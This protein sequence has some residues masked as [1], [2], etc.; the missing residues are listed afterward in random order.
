MSEDIKPEKKMRVQ[1][2]GM[3]CASCALKIE[4]SLNKLPGVKK[5]TVNFNLEN[6]YIEYD[7]KK[8]GFK[9]FNAAIEDI[10]YKSNL[11]RIELEISLLDSLE[12]AQMIQNFL[13]RQEGIYNA[14]VN[15]S[16]KVANIEYN[17]EEI[18]S[19]V[20]IQHI[21]RLGFEAIERVS[22]IDSEQLERE[23]EIKKQKFKFLFALIL[24][25]PI[26]TLSMWPTLNTLNE[27]RLLLFF[28]T[29]P[30]IVYSGNQFFIGSYRALRN[31][32][33]NMDVLV[34]LSVSVSFIYSTLVTFGVI[35]G[36]HVFYEAAVMILT[37]ILLGKYLEAIA[38]GR[39]S[40]AIKKL[41]GL[42]AKSATILR[43]GK[44][45]EIP[46]DEVQIGDT[47]ISKPGEKIPVDGVIIDGKTGIDESMITGESRLVKKRVGDSVI[48]A[49]I[50]KTGLIKFETKKIGKDTVLSQIIKLVQDAQS[51]KAPIQRLAD[52]VAGIFVPIV[53]L[54]AIVTFILWITIG[55]Q[56]LETALLAMTSVIV[57]AC[58]CA[59]GLAIPTAIM[60]GTGKGA[61]SGLLIKGG[62]SLEA[63]YKLT[64]V[65]FDKT[66]TLT[67]GKPEVTDIISDTLKD[68]DILRL[69]GSAEKGS[70]HPL[71]DAIISSANKR[72]ITLTSPKDFEEIPGNGIVAKIDTQLVYL[73]NQKLMDTHNIPVEKYNA[74]I[75]DLQ[76][77]GKTITYLA[78]NGQIEAL[79]GIADAIK[80]SSLS[81]IKALQ[82]KGLEVIMLTGDNTKTAHAIASQ[83]NIKNVISEILPQDKANQIKKLQMEGKKIVAMV[84]DGINDA[85]AL[86]QADVGIA[87]G[88]GTDVAIETGDIVLMRNDLRDVVAAINLSKKTV[89]KMKTNLFWAFIYNI[90]GIPLAAG[91]LFLLTGF[92][93][94]PGLAAAF[95]A[96][97]SVSVVTN[98]LLLK[99]YNPKMK[100]QIEED[101]RLA[102][103]IAIDPVCHMEVIPGKSLDSEYKGKTYYF[104]NP[105]CKIEFE[106]NPLKYITE[107]G[108]IP[109]EPLP[110]EL[111]ETPPKEVI[112]LTDKKPKLKC[113]SCNTTQEV[114]MHCGKPMHIEKVD[115]KP[116][117]VCWMGPGCG[118]Q[119]I[120]THHNAPMEYVE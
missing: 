120:P 41:L 49:T 92:F 38:K 44:E 99:S 39:T 104:C 64:T 52:R 70:D 71:A 112:E 108:E 55:G 65:V 4:N 78:V 85:P 9:N 105:N 47:V 36:M 114:P 40:E 83:L 19:K 76:V 51:Q 107:T 26:V 20:I 22:A 67:K 75:N 86:A 98:S 25:I 11:S 73:G 66:G 113:K 116:M 31:K 101:A 91:V 33:A 8:T 103:E 95:M 28:L 88:S 46:I 17:S 56:P 100:E 84:G 106:R 6:A 80:P 111:K 82:E 42:Q 15:L 37:F 59:M 102:G 97:S 50:N 3:T 14:Y 115:G 118:K 96:M 23:K 43:D 54:V 21:K 2:R 12:D 63:A 72:G 93:I 34:A 7:P 5:A 35:S 109:P 74:K 77:M 45:I 61:E 119:A 87:I 18:E 79:L 27:I 62:E 57:I 16:A 29:I 13:A 68:E 48:G 10:G 30:V 32:S 81:A 69:A 53:I 60:V 94:P 90:S 117:L 58:P 24:T 110:E 89:F 1:L